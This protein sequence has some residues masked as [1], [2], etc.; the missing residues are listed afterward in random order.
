MTPWCHLTSAEIRSSEVAD[1]AIAGTG[2]GIRLR[3]GRLAIDVEP[4]FD[5]K[6]LAD[7]LRVAGSAC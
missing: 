1:Q 7:V 6:L 3:I 5:P 2:T 4:G